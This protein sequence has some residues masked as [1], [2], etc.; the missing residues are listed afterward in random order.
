MKKSLKHITIIPDG[1]RR[2][3]KKRNLPSWQGH[4]EGAKKI[5]EAIKAME[6]HSEIN[7]L[8]FWIASKDNLIKRSKT[9]VAF[10]Y[11][12]FNKAF[13]LLIKSNAIDE[14]DVRVRILGEWQSLVPKNLG[15]TIKELEEKTRTNSKHNLTFLLGYSGTREMVVATNVLLDQQKRSID[16][17]DIKNA[18]IT[19]DLPPVDLLIRTGGEPH[20]SS[21]FMMWQTAN[22]Q[23]YFTDVLFP[24]FNKKELNKAIEEY[25]SRERRLGS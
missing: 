4:R 2:W 14:H 8:T 22:S 17:N 13:Q 25:Y 5:E 16:D 9:E 23:Y 7:Y 24:D 3:A 1:N 15:E 6:H 10:L 20:N 18:L 12:L 19:A 11:K 21:G